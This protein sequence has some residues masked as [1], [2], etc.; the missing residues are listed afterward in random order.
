MAL[1]SDGIWKHMADM[2]L[3]LAIGRVIEF[4]TRVLKLLNH[5][6]HAL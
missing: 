5:I 3:L 6:T 2:H 1:G 4:R